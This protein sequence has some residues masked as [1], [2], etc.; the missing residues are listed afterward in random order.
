VSKKNLQR[1]HDK[2]IKALASHA[3]KGKGKKNI[4]IISTPTQEHKKKDLSKI[5]SFNFLYIWSLCFS[6]PL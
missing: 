5:K 1:P 2:G 6:V 3:R 4:G